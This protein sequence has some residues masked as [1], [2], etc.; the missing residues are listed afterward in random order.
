[1]AREQVSQLANLELR[2]FKKRQ[3]K[4]LRAAGGSF[5]TQLVKYGTYVESVHI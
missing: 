4:G 1:M 3:F 2:Q 5:K